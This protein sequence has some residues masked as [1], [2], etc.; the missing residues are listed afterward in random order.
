MESSSAA[1]SL[2]RVVRDTNVLVSGR[3]SGGLERK[4]ESG[5]GRQATRMCIDGESFC[6]P[7]SQKR[8]MGHPAIFTPADW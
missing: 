3:L 6:F 7:M 5:C 8:D 4:T 1:S 2:L